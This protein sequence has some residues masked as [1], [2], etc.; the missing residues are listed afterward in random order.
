MKVISQRRA[1]SSSSL[2]VTSRQYV[3]KQLFTLALHVERGGGGGAGEGPS[4]C[5]HV[6]VCVCTH[7][8]GPAGVFEALY[9][10]P[11][12]LDV[13]C[14]FG[15]IIAH[16]GGRGGGGRRASAVVFQC[17]RGATLCILLLPRF[18]DRPQASDEV[19]KTTKKTNRKSAL[20]LFQL[21][22]SVN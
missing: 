11:S 7:A 4:L 18:V 17:E 9:R 14:T 3:N 13:Q 6:C 5:M 2:R 19:T 20:D 22:Q 16:L 1:H 21:F 10:F 8:A 15:F 12:P